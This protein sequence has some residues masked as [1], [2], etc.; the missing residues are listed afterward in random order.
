LPAAEPGEI[1]VPDGDLRAWVLSARVLR[2][3]GAFHD[4][5]LLT[6]RLATSGRPMLAWALRVMARD[7]CYIADAQGLERDITVG[8]LLRWS[9]RSFAN[10]GKA[11]CF[12]ASSAK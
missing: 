5:R 7:R 9:C 11:R 1:V 8:L 12:A 6:E 4:A 10:R 3:V 2:R